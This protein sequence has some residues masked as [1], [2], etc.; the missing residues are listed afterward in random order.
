[1]LNLE[2]AVKSKKE[3]LEK[4]DFDFEDILETKKTTVKSYNTGREQIS[5]ELALALGGPNIW[6]KISENRATISG[7]WG[8]SAYSEA[9][10][11]DNLYDYL[12]E[13]CY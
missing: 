11:N 4:E 10:E 13:M 12:L 7:Y 5:F 2:E 1:M 8:G 9:I 3:L 6:A